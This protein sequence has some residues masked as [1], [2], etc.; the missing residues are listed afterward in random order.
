MIA[1]LKRVD[2]DPKLTLELA[3]LAFVR[4]EDVRPRWVALGPDVD[5][6]KGSTG[7]LGLKR[8]Q[9]GCRAGHLMVGVGDP[10]PEEEQNRDD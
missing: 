3:A 5:L 2:R 4:R 7:P 1:L 8:I 10:E 9:N 6:P